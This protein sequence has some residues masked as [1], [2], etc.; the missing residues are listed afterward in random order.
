M[1]KPRRIQWATRAKLDL[2]AIAGY[3][4]RDNS[5]AAIDFT[6]Y[7]HQIV[8]NL[9]INPIG[10]PGELEGTVERVLSRYPSYL[11]IYKHDEALLRVVRVFHTAQGRKTH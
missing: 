1:K 3:I 10:R 9:A 8:A 6:L 2:N 4:V 5:Q 7:V 11:I